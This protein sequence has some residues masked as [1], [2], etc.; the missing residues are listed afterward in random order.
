[1]LTADQALD[2][3]WLDSLLL[4]KIYSFLSAT[5]NLLYSLISDLSVPF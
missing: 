4:Y 3:Y 1:M 5:F 2:E